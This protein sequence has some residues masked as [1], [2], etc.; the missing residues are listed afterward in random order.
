MQIF[1]VKTKPFSGSNYREVYHHATHYYRALIAGTRRRPYMRSRYF[2]KQKIFLG[3]FWQHLFD[4]N[5]HDRT[6][7]MKYLRCAI[8]LIAESPREPITVENPN[9]KSG[10]LH[11]FYGATPDGQIFIVQIKQDKRTRD[12]WFISVF[13]T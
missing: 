7:R 6:R 10:L 9:D 4:K 5:V 13:P 8:E 11:R 1:Q 2:K 12:K 3:L